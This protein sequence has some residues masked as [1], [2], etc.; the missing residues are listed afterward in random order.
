VVA[1]AVPPQVRGS[2][3][4]RRRVHVR[5]SGFGSQAHIGTKCGRLTS[6]VPSPVPNP[7]LPS[8]RAYVLTTGIV[9]GLLTLAHLWR[10]A[11][12]G[13]QLLTQPLWVGIT[14]GAGA[15]AVWAWRLLRQSR[16]T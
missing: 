3:A 6:P 4:G 14:V 9:F 8:M 7:G 13:V 10:I 2:R 16:P 11:A 15:L 1:D 5:R 12:E